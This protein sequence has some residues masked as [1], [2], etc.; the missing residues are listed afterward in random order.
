MGIRFGSRACVAVIAVVCTTAC[1]GRDARDFS[2]RWAPANQYAVRTEAIPL[3]GTYVYQASPMDGTLRNLLA[4]WARDSG[5]D[6]DYR[7]PSDFTL[8]QPV[9]SVRSH[10]LGD[11]LA[12]LGAAFGGQGVV[13]R[14][15]GSQLVVVAGAGGS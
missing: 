1:A 5:S 11:A 2:G 13:M 8:H 12:Q 7:H 9:R 15:E 10:D 14:M 6:L 3:H 4:R